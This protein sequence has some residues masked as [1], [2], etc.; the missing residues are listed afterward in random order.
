MDDYSI[1]KYYKGEKENPFVGKDTNHNHA[2]WWEG[3]KLFHEQW[4]QNKDFGKRIAQ[5]SNVKTTTNIEGKKRLLLA[6]LDL[7]VG[8][9]FPYATY[10]I[11]DY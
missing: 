10:T 5:I 3:E 9:W 8:K 7:W 1:Y 11:K 2:T 4:Q 6:Y